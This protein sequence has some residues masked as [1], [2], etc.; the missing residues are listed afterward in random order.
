MSIL[1]YSVC[2]PL[3]NYCNNYVY[4]SVISQFT[5]SSLS[6]LFPFPS[7]H[8]S[9]HIL[10]ISLSS[11]PLQVPEVI[12]SIRAV[13]KSALKED[14]KPKRDTGEAFYNSQKFEVLYCGKV[15]DHYQIHFQ[16]YCVF[17]INNL[18]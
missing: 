18:T 15:Q 17:I 10:H 12:S 16:T 14:S 8:F 1:N 2:F 3:T 4:I 13:S 5:L 7:S 9:L 6:P 11:L